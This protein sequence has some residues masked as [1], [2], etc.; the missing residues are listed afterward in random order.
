MV[1]GYLICRHLAVVLCL[2][3]SVG[4]SVRIG[5]KSVGVF[6]EFKMFLVGS[7]LAR[8]K[9]MKLRKICFLAHT[10]D[11]CMLKSGQTT[12]FASSLFLH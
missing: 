11:I 6:G 3:P 4:S 5:V 2:S 10:G 1:H 7:F 9:T 8:W 12:K